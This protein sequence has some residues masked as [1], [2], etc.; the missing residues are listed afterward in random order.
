[1][2]EEMLNTINGLDV[3]RK[4]LE[5]NQSEQKQLRAN[6]QSDINRFKELKGIK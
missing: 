4:M 1:L 2:A 3:Y 6:F 5:Q